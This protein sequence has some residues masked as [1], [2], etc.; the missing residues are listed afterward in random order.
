MLGAVVMLL[1]A[2]TSAGPDLDALNFEAFTFSDI[3]EPTLGAVDLT[4][5]SVFFPF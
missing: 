1:Q 3:V 5:Q 4:A 2:M